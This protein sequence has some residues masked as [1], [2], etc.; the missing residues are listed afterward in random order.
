LRELT[1]SAQRRTLQPVR[2]V[3]LQ[4]DLPY[5]VASSADSMVLSCAGAW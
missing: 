4:P 5:A 2:S 3:R 1:P